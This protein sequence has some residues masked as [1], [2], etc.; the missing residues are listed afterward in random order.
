MLTRE[1]RIAKI[2]R[3]HKQEPAV[4]ASFSEE[5]SLFAK[6][7]R[8]SDEATVNDFYLI[9]LRNENLDKREKELKRYK[10]YAP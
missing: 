9:V 5:Y 1:E 2:L 7:L 10:V 8:E 4:F 3:Q 6:G